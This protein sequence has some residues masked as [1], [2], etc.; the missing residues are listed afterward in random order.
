MAQFP[1]MGVSSSWLSEET[2]IELNKEIVLNIYVGNSK[3]SLSIG[4]LEDFREINCEAGVAFT[5][6]FSDKTMD[7]IE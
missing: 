1:D 4:N 6:T 5:V 3:N 2:E 7:E